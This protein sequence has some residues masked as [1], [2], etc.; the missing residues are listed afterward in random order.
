MENKVFFTILTLDKKIIKLENSNKL[1]AYQAFKSI[2]NA[3]SL[4]ET[5]TREILKK[6]DFQKV[7]T[8]MVKTDEFGKQFPHMRDMWKS[9]YISKRQKDV[10]FCTKNGE[11]LEDL[12][13]RGISLFE[14]GTKKR[15][16]KTVV[17]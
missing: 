9:I 13:N 5:S 4:M 7:S 1:C 12:K 14:N 15:K 10:T 16:R 6:R 11:S 8:L 2:N 17:I 3:V